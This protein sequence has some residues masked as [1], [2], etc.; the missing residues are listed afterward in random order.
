MGL[1]STTQK[2]GVTAF[3][4]QK[5]FSE[6][7][8]GDHKW[9]AAQRRYA[10]EGLKGYINADS[11][12]SAKGRVSAV[13]LKTYMNGL[14]ANQHKL[15]LTNEQLNKMEHTMD[16]YVKKNITKSQFFG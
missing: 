16:K 5:A 10:E 3:E 9:T 11:P 13:E 7:R 4:A 2:P 8:S 14:K 1:F 15:G 12:L 6:I